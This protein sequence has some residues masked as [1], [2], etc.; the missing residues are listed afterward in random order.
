MPDPKTRLPLVEPNALVA[1][2]AA[3]RRVLDLVE[4]VAPSDAT[5]LITG[6]SGTGKE[7]LARFIHERSKRGRTHF[8]AINC[9]A[10][11]ESLLESELFGHVKGSFTGAIRDK[12]GLFGASTKGTFFLD[13]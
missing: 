2:S 13:E 12:L 3:M 10:L 6:E 11:P 7:R 8:L 9:G 1:K 5:V 4:R